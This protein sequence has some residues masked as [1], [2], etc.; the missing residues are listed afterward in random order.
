ME[1]CREGIVVDVS[2][3]VAGIG[4][5]VRDFG[6]IYGKAVVVF[7]MLSDKD[8]DGACRLI[9]TIAS[10]VIVTAPDTERA[11]PADDTLRRMRVFFPDAAYAPSVA[12]AMDIA[13]GRAADG[14]T[15]LVTGSF[16]MAEEALAW[17]NR[18]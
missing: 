10:E 17:L 16:H 14:R 9:S 13:A 5:M 1:E 8:V 3:T 2:H 11:N 12:E 15:V 18:G 4:G 6:E 7:G